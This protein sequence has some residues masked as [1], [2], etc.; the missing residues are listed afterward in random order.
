M[1][2]LTTAR[3]PLW[4]WI[5]LGCLLLGQAVWIYLDATKRGERKR[6]FWGLFGL[7]NVPSSLLVY[8][9]VTRTLLKTRSCRACG[10]RIGAKALFCPECGRKQEGELPR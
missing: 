5:L 10:K 9:L 4:A 8:L 2:G 1:D 3:F 7:L 6:V